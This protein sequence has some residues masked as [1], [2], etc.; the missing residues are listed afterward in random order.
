MDPC[1]IRGEGTRK[2]RFMKNKDLKSD[3]I[4]NKIGGFLGYIRKNIIIFLGI[5]A[6]LVLGTYFLEKKVPT[7][8]ISK[9][10]KNMDA[11]MVADKIMLDLINNPN[12]CFKPGN[13]TYTNIDGSPIS[14]ESDCTITY[15]AANDTLEVVSLGTFSDYGS[16]KSY[17]INEAIVKHPNSNDIAYLG[18]L[19]LKDTS[20]FLEDNL[21]NIDHMKK[22][23][24]NKWFKTQAFLISG[25]S[26]SDNG[27][28]YKAKEDYGQ[29]IK[30]SQSNGQ[31]GYSNY[32]LGNVYLELNEF[33]DALLS[34]EKA[35]K[36]FESSKENQALNRNEQ[37]NGWI[38]RNSIALSKLKNILKK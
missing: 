17:I 10:E 6:L 33:D 12:V 22:N 32:K 1:S 4:A 16:I 5:I 9:E 2:W 28:F 14:S 7:L 13:V 20:Q 36:L 18:F 19:L 11:R 8:F 27:D 3:I 21:V 35:D 30:Y 26:H 25:D 15:T 37:F 23:I 24:D 29:A 34:F 38:D 31:K